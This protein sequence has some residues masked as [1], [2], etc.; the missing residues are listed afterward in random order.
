MDKHYESPTIEDHGDLAELT[1]G[2]THGKFLDA[3]FP[4]NT[5]IEE[6][7]LTV[8]PHAKP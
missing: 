7:T 8:T 6:V 3:T 4:E 5:P 1:A 2:K